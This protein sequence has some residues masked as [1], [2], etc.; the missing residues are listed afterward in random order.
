MSA[1]R[2]KQ[3]LGTCPI[4]DPL[5]DIVAEYATALLDDRLYWAIRRIS[6]KEL[7]LVSSSNIRRFRVTLDDDYGDVQFYD[8]AS[9]DRQLIGWTFVHTFLTNGWIMPRM[10]YDPLM[11]LMTLEEYV[12][13]LADCAIVEVDLA[14]EHR[15]RYPPTRS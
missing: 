3:E 2:I 9:I 8:V 13:S 15:F 5:L 7:T 6:G 1:P 10:G 14:Y 4:L 12:L 11:F